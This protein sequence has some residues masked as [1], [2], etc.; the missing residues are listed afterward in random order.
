MFA[1]LV[2]LYGIVFGTFGFFE[3]VNV[4]G[5]VA[6]IFY[7]FTLLKKTDKVESYE[8]DCLNFEVIEA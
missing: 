4:L 8:L 2:G 1:T 7:F 5:G 6:S 3:I